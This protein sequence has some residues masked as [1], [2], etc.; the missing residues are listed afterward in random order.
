[1]DYIALGDE[2]FRQ[3]RF[4]DAMMAYDSALLQDSSRSLGY[5]GYA[6]AALLFYG[7]RGGDIVADL[8]ATMDDPTEFAFL[9]H[10]DSILTRR[11]SGGGAALRAL[12]RLVDRDTLTRWWK[13]ADDSVTAQE[14]ADSLYAVR[15]AFMLDY[16]TKA[17][18]DFPGY[19]KRGKFPL[20]DFKIAREAI[21]TDFML[22]DMMYAFTR[23]YDLDRN[24]TVDARD[25]L[26]KKLQF[27]G[28]GG[29]TLDSLKNL[30]EELEN[31]TAAA[32]NLNALIAAMQLGLL[33]S[34]QLANLLIPPDSTEGDTTTS[35]D[36]VVANLG[37]AIMFYQFGD[38]IDNDGDGCVDEEILD[39]KDNDG[40]GFVDE[41][42]RVIPPNKPDGV[43]ND[44]DGRWDPVNP[45]LGFSPG[46]DSL[47]REDTVGTAV[48]AAKPWLLGFV[49]AY[50]T[51][52]PDS[53]F[54]KIRKGDANL[55][56]RIAIQK[57]SLA[58]KSPA[59]LAG[60][61]KAKLD[62]AK[63]LVGGCWRNYP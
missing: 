43:D 10:P 59:D 53:V 8:Q 15:R 20:S 26:M 63:A 58:T 62:S 46:T 17:D 44:H 24:D 5:Y 22:L 31:D 38:K 7:V 12:R 48:N 29:N 41:D 1:V 49:N 21:L 3:G 50:L 2:Y 18:L 54:V 32:A 30:A 11:L 27:G 37:D 16:F 47:G 39:E 25:S 33:N 13:Y 61:L 51:A 60:P 6:K 56:L 9:K 14:A 52:N 23:L 4:A 19:R 57:D 42:A 45:P 28:S 36:S 55:A 35:I 40:D 34:S